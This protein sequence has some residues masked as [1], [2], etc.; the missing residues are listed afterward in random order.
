MKVCVLVVAVLTCSSWS[1]AQDRGAVI[2]DR[3]SFSSSTHTV[4]E[5]HF[6]LEGGFGR[7]RYGSS[8]GYEMGEVLLRFGLSQRVEVRAQVPSYLVVRD[9]GGSI[10]GAGDVAIE[11]KYRFR[12]R[13]RAAFGVLASATLPT[14]SRG[15]AE[16]SFQPG[17]VLISDIAASR[18]V[19]VT[20]NVGYTRATKN[21][22]RY[23]YTFAASTIHV[24]LN[25]NLRMFMEVFLSH[26]Q[27]GPVQK[28]VSSG[29]VWTLGKRTALDIHGGVGLPGNNANGP[30]HYF[31]IGLSHLF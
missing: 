19:T 11:G 22:C 8:S 23:N 6:Q 29:L 15:V 2:P 14:G 7:F 13:D 31:G 28:Y 18:I 10:S 17:M 16:R 26:Q 1:Y 9:P 4:P 20:S 27:A 12:T 25:S 21:G 5:R 30:D 24:N 3:P